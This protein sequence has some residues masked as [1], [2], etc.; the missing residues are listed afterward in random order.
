[1]SA[2]I[3]DPAHIDV[4]LSSAIHGPKGVSRP[5]NAPYVNELLREA[6]RSGP[7]TQEAADLAGQALLRECVASVSYRYDEPLGELPGL[8]PNP[9]PEQYEWTDFGPLLTAIESCKAIACYEYQSCE[10]PAW[11]GSG[12]RAFCGRLRCSLIGHFDGYAE[13]EWEWSTEMALTR[14]PRSVRGLTARM[15]PSDGC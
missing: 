8:V 9:D 6:G 4:M 7:L 15:D 11:E 2:F 1:V 12:A 13:A 5:W 10:H 3:V 14:A